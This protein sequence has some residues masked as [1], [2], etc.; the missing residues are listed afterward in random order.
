MIWPCISE[1][2]STWI[3]PNQIIAIIPKFIIAEVIGFNNALILPTLI[4]DFK[5]S[6]LALSKRSS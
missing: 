4:D 6:S 3:P 5:K 1:P 2:E